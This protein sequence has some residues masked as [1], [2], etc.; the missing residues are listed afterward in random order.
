MMDDTLIEINKIHDIESISFGDI[1][2]LGEKNDRV[3]VPIL[4][5]NYDGA[6]FISLTSKDKHFNYFVKKVKEVYLK[7]KDTPL[8]G[9]FAPKYINIDNYSKS[10]LLSSNVSDT[11]E[12]YRHYEDIK[13]YSDKLLI[14]EVDI[15]IIKPL[16]EYAIN[17]NL[18]NFGFK[19][20]IDEMSGFYPGGNY[21]VTGYIDGVFIKLPIRITKDNTNYNIDIARIEKIND[22]L[23]I[24]ITFDKTKLEIISKMTNSGY[25]FYDEYAYKDNK[26]I[27]TKEVY[28]GG[29]CRLYNQEEVTNK[30]EIQA[31]DENEKMNAFILPWGA[32]LAFDFEEDNPDIFTKV[33]TRKM[34][35]YVKDKNSFMDITTAEKRVTKRTN[36]NHLISDIIFDDVDKRVIGLRKDG[37]TYIETTFFN[38]GATGEYNEKYAGKYF[39]Q[40]SNVPID[41]LSKDNIYPIRDE[42][43]IFSR[44]EL[45]NKRKLRQI[46]KEKKHGTI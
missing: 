45:R 42:D 21:Q 43:N 40:V 33:Q 9:F 30:S 19:F 28:L 8:K 39:Y 41:E 11:S 24:S 15:S 6:N 22:F 37:I 29:R 35:Y 27:N 32:N 18:S 10:I 36:T 31:V 13:G 46:T 38:D 44:S 3:Y 7:E 26:L 14:N 23:N 34:K 25:V 1:A 4:T 16:I 2:L 17:S 20:E 12:L 5:I